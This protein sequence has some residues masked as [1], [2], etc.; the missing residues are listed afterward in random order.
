MVRL[1]RDRHHAIVESAT[2]LPDD[3][4]AEVQANLTKLYGTALETS[5]TENPA[6]IAGMRVRVGSDVYDGSVRARLAAIDAG[7]SE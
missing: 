2:A 6:L 4:R 3:L 5:F 1:T 7:L